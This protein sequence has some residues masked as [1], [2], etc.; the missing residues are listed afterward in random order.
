[1]EEP[2]K[3]FEVPKPVSVGDS[4]TVKIESQGGHGDGIAKVDGFIVF[5]KSAAKGEE[6]KIKI[7]D[8]KRTYAIAEKVH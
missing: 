6:C 2:R 7:I 8:V 5:V 3:K 4:L 1:M